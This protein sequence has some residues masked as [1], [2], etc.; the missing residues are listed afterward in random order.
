MSTSRRETLSKKIPL[1]GV[2]FYLINVLLFP[3]TLIGYV[4]HVSHLYLGR[5]SGASTSAQGPLAA[6]WT[7]HHLGVREDEAASRLM[8]SVLGAFPLGWYLAAG[9]VLL[10]HRLTGWVPKAFRY[11][12]EGEVA[13]QY[14]ASARQTFFDTVVERYLANLTQFVILGAGFDTRAYQL[15]KQTQVR[16]FEVDTPKTQAVKRQ[17]LEKTRIDASRV[18]FVSADFEKEDWFSRLVQAG[19]DPSKRTLLLWEGV[20]H[21]LDREAV[22]TTLRRIASSAKGS[23]VAF[24]YFTTEPLKSQALYWRFGRAAAKAAGEPLK[25]GIDST[26]P[27][28]QGLAELLQSCGLRLLEQRTLG[29]ETGGKRA[30]GG[31]ATAIVI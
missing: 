1:A 25:F 12:Y 29:D 14:Q 2:I 5:R 31:F 13:V 18:S 24:D 30:W 3:L 27:S 19:F 4:L 23:V 7:Q 26:P 17:L 6:R 10:A 8:V 21:Y 11:P 28:R 15:P 16:A 9:P 22:E 20:I